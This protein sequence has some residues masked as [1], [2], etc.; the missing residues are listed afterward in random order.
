MHSLTLLR[1]AL[2]FCFVLAGGAKLF[3]A[4][5]L[6]K[7]FEEFG[8]PHWAMR[9][10]GVLEVSGAAGLQVPSLAFWASVGLAA[11]MTGAVANHLKVQHPLAQ[12]AP[13]IVLLMGCLAAALVLRGG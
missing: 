11:L 13:A 9:A 12:S 2:T 4:K 7:Q 6:K 8:L 10:V 5:P 1:G 3:G